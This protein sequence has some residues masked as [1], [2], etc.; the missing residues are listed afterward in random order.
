[1]VPGAWN[2]IRD[3]GVI[4]DVADMDLVGNRRNV[5]HHPLL[6]FGAAPVDVTVCH[7]HAASGGPI[8]AC[9]VFIAPCARCGLRRTK[10]AAEGQNEIDE[11]KG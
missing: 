9:R 4:Q 3:S 2:V 6:R 7:S 5:R 10:R 11:S 8:H 1:M